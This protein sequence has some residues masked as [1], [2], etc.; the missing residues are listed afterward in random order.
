MYGWH[1]IIVLCLGKINDMKILFLFCFI[2]IANYSVAQTKNDPVSLRDDGLP[3]VSPRDADLQEGD[4]IQEDYQQTRQ[5][6]PG[7]INRTDEPEAQPLEYRS[8]F[9]PEERVKHFENDTTRVKAKPIMNPSGQ[10]P[11]VTPD[12]SSAGGTNAP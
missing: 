1:G 3:L 2:I 12:T 7:T 6:I 10:E 4:R 9:D 11:K 5:H 8:P